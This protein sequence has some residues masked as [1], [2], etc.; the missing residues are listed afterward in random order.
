MSPFCRCGATCLKRGVPSSAPCSVP[1]PPD[2]P[3]PPNPSPTP[4]SPAPL[5]P[6]PPFPGGRGAGGAACRGVR[7]RRRG[8]AEGRRCGGLREGCAPNSSTP[9]CSNRTRRWWRDAHRWVVG[10]AFFCASLS[11]VSE[12]PDVVC[13][14]CHMP[15]LGSQKVPSSLLETSKSAHEVIR[16]TA[17]PPPA[18][19]SQGNKS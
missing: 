15:S 5:P 6:P 13:F 11:Y 12:P 10:C 2:V 17:S 14:F 16:R 3:P 7:R 8:A 9:C 1:T 4:G 19:L 18:S